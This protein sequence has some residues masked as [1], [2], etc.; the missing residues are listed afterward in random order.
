MVLG[1]RV[2][3]KKAKRRSLEFISGVIILNIEENGKI[4]R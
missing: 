3:I 4:I 1:M 2:G